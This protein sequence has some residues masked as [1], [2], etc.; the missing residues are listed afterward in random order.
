ML[1]WMQITHCTIIGLVN[2]RN[3]QRCKLFKIYFNLRWEKPTC[4]RFL[5]LSLRHRL[6]NKYQNNENVVFSNHHR[7]L[8]ILYRNMYYNKTKLINNMFRIIALCF[9]K[10]EKWKSIN[11]YVSLETFERKVNQL[12]RREF[13]V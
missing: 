4:Y 9:K 3:A 5:K 6:H 10:E 8:I 12:L 13:N 11:K 7:D 2:N 1:W